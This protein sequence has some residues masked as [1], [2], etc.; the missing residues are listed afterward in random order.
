MSK[1]RHTIIVGSTSE[2]KVSPTY[3]ACV[4]LGIFANVRGEDIPSGVNAQ[5]EGFDEIY[6]GASNRARGAAKTEE[7]ACGVGIENGIVRFGG[8][9]GKRFAINLAVI[10]LCLP[11]G[12]EFVAVSEGIAYPDECVRDAERI[13]FETMTVGKMFADR[14]GG[15]PTDPYVIGS[16]GRVTRRKLLAEPL[17]QVLFEAFSQESRSEA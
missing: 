15:D 11:D 1:I 10:V 12:R 16:G 7:G 17:K 9:D 2:H 4:S 3:A 5:P 13:G 14:L 8:E 6:R